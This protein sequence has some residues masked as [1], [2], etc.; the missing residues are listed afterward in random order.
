MCFVVTVVNWLFTNTI[1]MIV[2]LELEILNQSLH[3][4]L[5]H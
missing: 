4:E 2:T 5:N 1:T 3:D